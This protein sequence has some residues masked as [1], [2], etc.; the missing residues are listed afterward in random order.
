[1]E[2]DEIGSEEKT[3]L[4]EFEENDQYIEDLFYLSNDSSSGHNRNE[5]IIIVKDIIQQ[6]DNIINLFYRIHF[7]FFKY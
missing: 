6:A 2:E 1:M 7:H 3:Q 5:A 4:D